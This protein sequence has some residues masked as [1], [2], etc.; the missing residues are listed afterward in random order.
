MK[1]YIVVIVALLT[2]F[3]VRAQEF[4]PMEHDGLLYQELFHNNAE[5]GK[6]PLII[7]LLADMPAETTTKNNFPRLVFRK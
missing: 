5:K 3:C 6:V 2:G 4:K 1:R 7:Y